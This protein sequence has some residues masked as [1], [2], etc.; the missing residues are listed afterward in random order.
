MNKALFLDRDGV[1][2]KMVKYDN[3]WDSPQNPNGVKLV[4]GTEKIISWA[5]KNNILVVE[6][7]NQPG[8]AK[9]KMTQ[10]MSD[11]V[12]KQIHLLL[13]K[14]GAV[15]DKVYFCPH[16]PEAVIPEFK[17]V[18]N[19]RKPKPGL[20]LRATKELK[21][22]LTK[23]IMLGDK[24]GDVEAGKK[25]GCKTII[26]IHNEDA[27]NKVDESKKVKADYKISKISDAI[28]LIREEFKSM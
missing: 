8:V 10:T 28:N 2:N 15:I 18:C 25:A 7:S 17:K 3:G 4:N 19:C 6:I 27:K 26:F 20:L 14:R 5:N 23:S 1:I 13:K 9:G 11:D 21:I 22:D 16:H 24:A 12:E